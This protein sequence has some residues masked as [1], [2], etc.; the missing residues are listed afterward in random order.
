MQEAVIQISIPKADI[1]LLHSGA[2]MCLIIPCSSTPTLSNNIIQK[3][4][5]FGRD[6]SGTVIN[7]GR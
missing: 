3:G 4:L 1:D 2:A 7:S 5:A 6:R